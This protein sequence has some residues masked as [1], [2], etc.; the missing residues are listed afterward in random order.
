M[1]LFVADELGDLDEVRS[2]TKYTAGAELNVSIGLARLGY[3]SKYGTILGVD[4]LGKYIKD[5]MKDENINTEY[6]YYNEDFQT[7][8]MFKSKVENGDPKIAY[9]R[10]NSACTHFGVETSKEFDLE[11]IDLFHG[12]GI[13]LG[14][15]KDTR[16][17]MFSLKERCLKNNVKFTFDPNIRPALWEN[18]DIMVNSINKLAE[19]CDYILPGIEEGEILTGFT[20]AS[21]IADFYLK[22]G[23]KNIIV[24]TGA[25]GAYY[26][27]HLGN[28]GF[29]EGFKVDRVVDTVG[30]GDGFATGIISGILDECSIADTIKRGC[31]I[32]AIQVTNKSDN[33]GL[34]N[35]DELFSFMK[36]G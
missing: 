23:V 1:G 29:V 7:G 24:K 30:A 20:D 36:R 31:A 27:T 18:Q 32:G 16:E 13:M 28:E 15:S 2:F 33:E 17:M 21:D 25:K 26:K 14:V 6:V 12:T 35:K 34:P 8:L 9:Y 11:K 19:N 3:N 5:F 22:L 10:K 4:P